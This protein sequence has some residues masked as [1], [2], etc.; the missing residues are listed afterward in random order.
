MN[1]RGTEAC[2]SRCLFSLASPTTLIPGP[3]DNLI[4]PP[5]GTR[6]G[7]SG[8]L[9]FR[10]LTGSP[11]ETSPSHDPSESQSSLHPP[12][13]EPP[14]PRAGGVLTVPRPRSRE[15]AALLRLEIRRLPPEEQAEMQRLRM[16]A[17]EMAIPEDALWMFLPESSRPAIPVRHDAFRFRRCTA[18]RLRIRSRV[19]RRPAWRARALPIPPGLPSA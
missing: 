7:L 8:G 11:P 10:Q 19:G 18:A 1:R 4:P 13:G 9:P 15:A 16:T 17:L 12:L 2:S 5:Y 6:M 14:A 3:P